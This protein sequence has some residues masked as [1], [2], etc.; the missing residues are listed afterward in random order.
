MSRGWR[1]VVLR[2]LIAAGDRCRGRGGDVELCAATPGLTRALRGSGGGEYRV[3]A[4]RACT[5]MTT[6]SLER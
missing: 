4:G 2:E 1:D 6:Q 5:G 3:T